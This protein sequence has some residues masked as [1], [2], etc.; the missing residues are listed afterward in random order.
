M[1]PDRGAGQ[2]ALH[3]V[4]EVGPEVVGGEVP[5]VAEA[6]PEPSPEGEQSTFLVCQ[7][8]Q[9]D[10]FLNGEKLVKLFGE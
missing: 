5:P 1:Q 8:P 4:K 10:V 9:G 7:S 2:L 3:A 6:F